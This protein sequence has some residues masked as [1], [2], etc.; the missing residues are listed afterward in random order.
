MSRKKLLI[1]TQHIFP[2]QTPR[3]LRSTELIKEFGKRG[4]DVTVYAVFGDYDYSEF[5]K[6]Y[7]VTLKSISLKWQF[8]PYS[9]DG[10]GKRNLI[11]RVLVKGLG[12]RY[13]FPDIEFKH[14]ME[15]I[16]EKESDSDVVIS[17]ANPHPIHWGV[18]RAR[19]KLSKFPPLWIAD[20]GDP[21]MKNNKGGKGLQFEKE[22]RA[23]C[24]EVDFITVPVA[25]AVDGYYKEFR[26]KIKVIPQG[27]DFNLNQKEPLVSD[28]MR[29]LYAGVFI[30]E[31]REPNELFE[32]LIESDKDFEFHV[33]TPYTN[34]I[35][36]YRSKLEGKLVIHNVIPRTDLLK[37]IEGMS[38]VVNVTNKNTSTQ[39]PSKLID[40]AISSK[41]ILNIKN[42]NKAENKDLVNKFLQADYSGQLIVE[43]LE[44]YHI[45]N[46]VDQFE[47][48]F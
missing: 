47:K 28:K 15:E 9:S 30:P 22:E 37:V 12:K 43:N 26:K 29:F 34:L 21:Y 4:Y 13:E 11:D 20:C 36:K 23:F 40:Y 38:F 45:S 18:A 41:P 2:I 44:K 14:R 3:S 46:V 5:C 33:Y 27:F 25:E 31:I 35:D 19:K 24:S 16:L 39:I 10:K 1:I 48:L 17:I 42:G 7:N 6:K 8:K 32:I